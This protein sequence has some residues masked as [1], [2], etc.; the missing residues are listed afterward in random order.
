VIYRSFEA[1]RI[2]TNYGSECDFALSGK[3]HHYAALLQYSNYTA[4]SAT[5][6][7]IARNTSKLWAQLEY[8]W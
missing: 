2:S 3:W 5:P 4:A 6:V 8:L 7:A 1:E